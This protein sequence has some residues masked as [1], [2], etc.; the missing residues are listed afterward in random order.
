MPIIQVADEQRLMQSI[1]GPTGPTGPG[2]GGGG[3]TGYTGPAGPTGAT[4]PDGTP[5]TPGAPGSAG[6][7]GPTGP[8]GD[9]G[10][11]GP[12]G[13]TG[14]TGLTGV[15]GPTG[16][17]GVTG[18][19]GS[20]GPTGFGATGPTGITGPTGATGPT[21]HTGPT[22]VDGSLFKVTRVFKQYKGTPG[23]AAGTPQTLPSATFTKVLYNASVSSPGYNYGSQWDATTNRWTPGIDGLCIVNFQVYIT[24]TFTSPANAFLTINKDGVVT[25][26]NQMVNSFQQSIFNNAVVFTVTATFVSVP[27][28]YYECI[29]YLAHAGTA[30]IIADG[31]TFIAGAVIPFQP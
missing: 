7:T 4:G 21:G 14:A 29:V 3:G 20:T 17:T 11:T 31:N 1:I 26:A 15:T 23:A 10:P 28:S 19:T 13:I 2:S 25:V 18:A 16:S 5:G 30:N 9:I 27:G 22:G 12:T 6:A 24:G 8:T